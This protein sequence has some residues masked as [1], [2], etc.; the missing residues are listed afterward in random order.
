M[1]YPKDGKNRISFPE[2][3]NETIWLAVNPDRSNKAVEFA[4]NTILPFNKVY[5]S[6]SQL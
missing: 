4:S 2:V 3:F 6:S 5:E 1:C